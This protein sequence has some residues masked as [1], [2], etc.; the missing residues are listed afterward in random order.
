MAYECREGASRRRRHWPEAEKRRIAAEV[1]VDGASLSDVARRH[2][3]HGSVIGRW[4]ERFG[5]ASAPATPFLPV[6]VA[7]PEAALP[8]AA[9]SMVAQTREAVV[10]VVL[11]N[12]R[13][14]VVAESIAPPRL[15][16]LIA[17]VEAA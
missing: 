8:P 17:A 13:R 12:G 7:A 2:G 6:T 10:E 3:I 9:P 11:A 15:R 1:G 14:L 4:C 16:V 5:E